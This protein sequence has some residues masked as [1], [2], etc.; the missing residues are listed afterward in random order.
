MCWCCNHRLVRPALLSAA[1]QRSAFR[2]ATVWFFCILM[3]RR[4]W[5]SGPC[6]MSHLLPPH[7]TCRCS[8]P[9]PQCSEHAKTRFVL[10]ASA[11]VQVLRAAVTAPIHGSQSPKPGTW[12]ATA[13]RLVNLKRHWT[14]KPDLRH[15]LQRLSYRRHLLEPKLCIR[16]EGQL[17]RRRFP[18]A[19][20]SANGPFAV[21]PVVAWLISVKP[22]PRKLK[23]PNDL[24]AHFHRA[25]RTI[26]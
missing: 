6:G 15:S 7:P 12:D 13:R 1:A 5:W 11:P 8:T 16:I 3:A 4:R 24:S 17:C 9:I 25:G 14:S 18:L 26:T 19:G 10:A 22:R 21:N 23:F 20:L 2:P